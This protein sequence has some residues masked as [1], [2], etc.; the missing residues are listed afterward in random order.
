VNGSKVYNY[1]YYKQERQIRKL[2]NLFCEFLSLHP[3]S[4][5]SWKSEHCSTT[6][7]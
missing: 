5:K 6:C 4:C 3:A 7:I 1:A 2:S